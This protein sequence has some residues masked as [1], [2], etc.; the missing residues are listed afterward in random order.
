MGQAKAFGLWVTGLRVMFSSLE[1][2]LS[3]IRIPRVKEGLVLA[4]VPRND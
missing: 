2:N 3:V 4:I 1:K